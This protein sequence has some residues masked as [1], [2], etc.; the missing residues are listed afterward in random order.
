MKRI[1]VLLAALSLTTA[2]SAV[3]PS[4]YAGAHR[5]EGVSIPRSEFFSFDIRED[6]EAGNISA[7]KFFKATNGSADENGVYKF[8]L[9]APYAFQ[10]RD[11][12]FHSDGG[13]GRFAVYVNDH[14]AGISHDSQT[15]SEVFI[16]PYL[17]PGINR[18]DVAVSD[19]I[20]GGVVENK[21]RDP[22][23]PLSGSAYIYSQPKVHI[24]DYDILGSQDSTGLH[25]ILALDIAVSNGFRTDQTFSAGF[26]IYSPEGKLK[27]F[28]MREITLAPL[29]SDTVHF[30]RPIYSTASR[31]WSA[32]SPKLYRVMLFIKQ[33]G[34]IIEYIPL[35]LGW[36][37]T[38]YA[39]GRIL[40]N[41][42]PINIKAVEYSPNYSMSLDEQL[43]T[44]KKR[45]FN[46]VY[47]KYPAQI[48]FYRAADRV[49]MYVVDC[50]DINT[51][52]CNGNINP[53]GTIVNNP[54]YLNEMLSRT[55][56]MQRRTRNN[57]CVIAWNLAA[58]G[59]N[60]Y[61]LYKTYRLLHSLDTLR[62]AVYRL[63]DGCWNSDIE[64]P[65][66]SKLR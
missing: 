50:A 17:I 20:S 65:E 55:L 44:L 3:Q 16:S 28:D 64:L 10:E 66:P 46:T 53:D 57:S 15:A 41:G 1:F 14:L 49:G 26:D 29:S 37:V 4:P 36:G 59:G 62:P 13:W 21:L 38:T 7:S 31:L 18:I 34:K 43:T 25:G 24:V 27:E 6:A 48:A 11:V 58:N 39:D 54:K 23:L 45:G 52:P 42:K 8:T 9:F 60:G 51:D 61:N 33:G 63:A 19:T 30:R 32:E 40:R 35:K 12:F 2:L 22:I 5:P 47:L 56:A